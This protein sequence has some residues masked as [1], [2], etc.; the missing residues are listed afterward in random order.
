MSQVSLDLKKWLWILILLPVV[1]N[2]MWLLWNN[3][4]ISEYENNLNI[5]KWKG[6]FVPALRKVSTSLTKRKI[7]AIAFLFLRRNG[8]IP[9]DYFLF[10]PYWLFISW[11]EKKVY[12]Q[13]V[14]FFMGEF[15]WIYYSHNPI[16]NLKR[17]RDSLKGISVLKFL[18]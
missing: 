6:M 9:I 4:P 14:L 15:C 2:D 7:W 1:W 13:R 18:F 12:N 10:S 17:R 16:Y 3:M 8:E 11:F 5:A